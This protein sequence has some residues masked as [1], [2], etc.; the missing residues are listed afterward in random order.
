MYI[1]KTIISTLLN[2]PLVFIFTNYYNCE[3]STQSTVY[4]HQINFVVYTVPFIIWISVF[5]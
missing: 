2:K 5:I 1:Y 3:M 4:I